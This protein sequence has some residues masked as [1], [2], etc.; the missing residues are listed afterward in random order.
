MTDHELEID[1]ER[2][3]E[4][5]ATAATSRIGVSADSGVVMLSGYVAS[6]VEK[7]AVESATARVPGV[8]AIANELVVNPYIDTLPCDSEIALRCADA[9]REQRF[10]DAVRFVVSRRWVTL[11]GTVPQDYQRRAAELAV[12]HLRGVVGVTNNVQLT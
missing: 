4:R 6:A 2:E 9:I 11:E 3:L 7:D 8:V 12:K 5:E 1:V 10:D